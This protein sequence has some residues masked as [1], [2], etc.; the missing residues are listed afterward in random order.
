MTDPTMGAR[1]RHIPGIGYW[2]AKAAF[3]HPHRTALVTP[4]GRRSY[5]ELEEGVAAAA[6]LLRGRGI[7]PGHRFG[8]LM[9]NDPRFLELLFAA[10]RVGAVAVP[11]NWR[12]AAPELVFQTEDAGIDLLFV[13][14]EQTELGGEVAEATGCRV[15]PVPSAYDREAARARSGQGASGGPPPPMSTLPGDDDPVL[16]VYTSGTTG[17]PKGAVLTHRNLFWNAINDILALGIT[18][19]DTSLTVLPL[20]HAGGIGLFTLP[21]LLAGGTVVLPRRFDPD[22]TLALIRDEQVTLMLGV[23]AIHTLLVDS[24]AWDEADLSSLRFM[25]N[26]GD[27]CPDRVGARFRERG[28]PFASGYGLTETA[29]TAFLT[30]LDDPGRGAGIVGKPAFGVDARIVDG[31]GRDVAPG[32]VGEVVFQGPNLF[33][34]Y[35]RRP[36]ATAEAFQDGWFHSGDLARWSEG[37]L[38][39]I[40]GRKKQMLKSGGENIYPA[41]VEQALL[42]HPEVSEACVIGRPH[43]VW[44]EVPFA[45]V[46]M[47]GGP[48]EGAGADSGSRDDELRRFLAERLARY[49]IPKG[50]AFVD[51]LPRTSI[52][53]PDRPLLEHRYGG[54]MDP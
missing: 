50:F 45:V 40:A 5:Q 35:W 49:K 31:E 10:G 43:P 51:A 32:D 37:G 53:K 20:M 6:A 33:R 30:G 9:W 1:S 22:E 48:E 46:A 38:T 16:M 12:L 18:W 7:G 17:R 24:P 54:E 8:I 34:E 26:G 15:I 36:D 42:E 23:P 14:P 27:R 4:E 52:G 2:T 28:V 13:G 47:R 44:N 19:E 25:Y 29:P 39:R 41:E 21:T 11:L 3:L